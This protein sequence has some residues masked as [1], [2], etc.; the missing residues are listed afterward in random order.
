MFVTDVESGKLVRVIDEH[1][2]GV[3]GV[4]LHSADADGPLH[5]ATGGEDHCVNVVKVTRMPV[6]SVNLQYSL[7]WPNA[8]HLISHTESRKRSL[9]VR[10]RFVILLFRSISDPLNDML[11]WLCPSMSLIRSAFAIGMHSSTMASQ[12]ESKEKL[13]GMPDYTRGPAPATG[14]TR[15]AAEQLVVFAQLMSFPFA[16]DLPFSVTEDR[17][18]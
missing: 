18:R 12:V 4:A 7:A 11:A 1:S 15:V 17:L 9:D 14:L 10:S 2:A 5:I 6:L 3:K 8:M 13:V 16:I